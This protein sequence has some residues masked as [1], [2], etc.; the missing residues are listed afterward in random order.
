[1]EIAERYRW[2]AETA[3]GKILTRGEDLTQCVRFSLI[4]A[5]GVRLPRHDIVDVPMLRRFCRGF[6]K[7]HFNPKQQ[8][9]GKVFWADGSVEQKTEVDL[10]AHIGPGDLIGKGVAGEKWYPVRE[11]YEDRVVL[12]AP[13]AGHSKPRGMFARKIKAGIASQ[14]RQYVHCVCCLGCRIW[15]N[16]VTG[17]V[18]VTDRDREIY[19]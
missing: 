8:L 16:Y 7:T 11:V 9:P 3:D 15:I 10:R 18:L 4:P 5:D 1:V 13:Y 19:L 2:E 12:L 17:T 6:L 14:T